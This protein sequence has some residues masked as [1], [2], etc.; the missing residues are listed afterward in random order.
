MGGQDKGLIPFSGKP[1]IE[2]TAENLTQQGATFIINAN[3][4]QNIYQRYA[5]TFS[6]LNQDFQG[7][8]AGMQA[9]MTHH[10]A[11]WYG[12]VPCDTPHLPANLIQTM[13]Q[14]IDNEHEILVAYDGSYIQPTVAMLKCTT[15]PKLEAFLAQG[16]RKLRQFYQQCQTK[17]IDFSDQPQAFVNLNTREEL[18]SYE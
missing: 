12:F 4:N 17:Q 6:D 5:D 7:P 2:H 16:N 10:Q 3:R 9:A 13:Q 11:D 18:A 1:L 8:L 14:A 15:K